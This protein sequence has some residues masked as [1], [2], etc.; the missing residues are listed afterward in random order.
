MKCILNYDSNVFFILYR[1]HSYIYLDVIVW[2]GFFL[3]GLL[4]E[5]LVWLRANHCHHETYNAKNIFQNLHIITLF[6]SRHLLLFNT[7][8]DQYLIDWLSLIRMSLNILRPAHYRLL[9]FS[10]RHN[11]MQLIIFFQIFRQWE[12][13]LKLFSDFIILFIFLLKQLVFA[14]SDDFNHFEGVPLLN[15]FRDGF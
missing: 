9:P 13:V 11:G 15:I 2:R 7:G 4:H 3:W 1:L 6:F 10:Q 5:V 8:L 12:K 14:I